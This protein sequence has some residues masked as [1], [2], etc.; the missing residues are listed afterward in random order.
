[1][2]CASYDFG[3]IPVVSYP[4]V[5]NDGLVSAHAAS[6]VDTIGVLFEAAKSNPSVR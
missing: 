4:D 1:M 5:I 3:I 2:A 6:K